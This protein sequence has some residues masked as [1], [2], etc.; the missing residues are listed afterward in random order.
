MARADEAIRSD[1]LTHLEWDTRVNATHIRVLVSRGVVRLEGS[2]ETA[3][4]RSAA[5]SD[6]SV[7]GGVKDVD[8]RLLVRSPQSSPVLGDAELKAAIINLLDA[9]ANV[10]LS[11]I[12]VTVEE[13][14]VTLRGSVDS[15]WKRNHI[16]AVVSQ[17][18]RVF[19][20]DNDLAV[21]PIREA[22]DDTIA[23]DIGGALRRHTL[24]TNA[25]LKTHAGNGRVVLSGSVPSYA[26]RQAA[27]DIASCTFGVTEVVDEL[28]IDDS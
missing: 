27:R 22:T 24:L 26:A 7:V 28:T 12:A 5:V 18:R 15:L 11:S 16:E 20:V 21:K 3:L 1:I 4:A 17:Q 10:D 19:G 25:P 2:V 8:A 14:R 13:G 9:D 6:A 23:R